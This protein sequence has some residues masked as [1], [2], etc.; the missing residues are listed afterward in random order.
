MNRESP[1]KGKKD[2]L[3]AVAKMYNV[4]LD[5]IRARHD[6]TEVSIAYRFVYDRPIEY[7]EFSIIN[8]LNQEMP[9]VRP[10]SARI[11]HTVPFEITTFLSSI[12]LVREKVIVYLSST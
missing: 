2:Y 4:N 1:L 8:M 6:D 10:E 7:T 9:E 5:Y 3:K 11:L 12:E